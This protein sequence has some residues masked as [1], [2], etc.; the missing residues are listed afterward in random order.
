[1]WSDNSVEKV[2]PGAHLQ[3]KFI[4][5]TFSR[6]QKLLYS[7]WYAGKTQKRTTIALQPLPGTSE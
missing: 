1:M 2:T 3:T 5:A 4:L 7:S 6:K